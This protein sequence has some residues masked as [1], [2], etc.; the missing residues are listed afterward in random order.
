MNA[1]Y[2]K[3]SCS[4]LSTAAEEHTLRPVDEQLQQKKVRRFLT[5]RFKLSSLPQRELIDSLS[6][7]VK[8]LQ[9]EQAAVNEEQQGLTEIFESIR[10][11]LL[12]DPELLH[13][14]DTYVDDVEQVLY[15]NAQAKNH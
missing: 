10:Q 12:D 4:S 13:R 11:Q 3:A 9:E 6:R 1:V 14:V 7:K 15:S 2:R 8:I 5:P